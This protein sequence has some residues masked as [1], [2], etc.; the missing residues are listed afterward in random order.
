MAAPALNQSAILVRRHARPALAVALCFFN[1]AAAPLS[2]VDD[3]VGAWEMTLDGSHR[4]CRVMLGAESTGDPSRVLR[5]P[6]GCRRALPVLNVTAA[7]R[8]ENGLIRFVGKGGEPILAFVPRGDE[9]GLIARTATGEVFLL[10]LQERPVRP[11]PVSTPFT[12]PRP[13]R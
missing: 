7:W 9:E 2:G 1:M 6:A 8:F 12:S 11:E 13:R 3:P 10:G 4:K 5:F